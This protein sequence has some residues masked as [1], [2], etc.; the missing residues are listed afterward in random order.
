MSQATDSDIGGC[1]CLL[2]VGLFV[3]ACIVL[4]NVRDEWKSTREDLTEIKTQV[5]EI[6]A[7]AAK[8]ETKGV[9]P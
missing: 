3:V 1:G 6:N 2:V 8:T 5:R 4:A 9:K 7:R